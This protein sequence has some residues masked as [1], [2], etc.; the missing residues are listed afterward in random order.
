MQWISGGGKPEE[1][2]IVVEPENGL[3]TPELLFCS[4]KCFH[5]AGYEVCTRCGRSAL[6]SEGGW[7]GFDFPSFLCALC[8][9]EESPSSKEKDPCDPDYLE[10]N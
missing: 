4:E 5:E 3:E 6:E 10:K 2:A 8:V 1:G 7:E 9:R